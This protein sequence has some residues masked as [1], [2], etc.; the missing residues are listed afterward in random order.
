MSNNQKM[1]EV[2]RCRWRQLMETKVGIDKIGVYIPP[3]YLDMDNLADAR[4]VEADKFKIGIGQDKMSVATIEQDIVAM[5][6]NAAAD[7]LTDEDKTLI[8]QVIFATESGFDFSKA[9][10]VFIHELLEIQPFAKSFEIKQACYGAT[11]AVQTASDYIR[12]RPDRKILIIS[13]DISRYG[14]N[15]SGESTQGAGAIAI[16]MSAN[17]KILSLDMDSISLTENQFDFWRPSYSEVA[18]IEGKFSTQLYQEFFGR[19]M[20][21]MEAQYPE[22]LQQVDAMVFHLPFTKMGKKALD[23]YNEVSE[24]HL[25]L[26][27]KQQLINRWRGHYDSSTVLNREVGNI[28]TGS[29]F[30]SMLSLLVFDDD[31]SSGDKIGLFSYGSGAVAELITGTIEDQYLTTINKESILAHFNRREELDIER[32]EEIYQARIPMSDDKVIVCE[33]PIEEGFYLAEVDAHRRY[34]GNTKRK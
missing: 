22:R 33:N 28:Y 1:V 7:I 32:Y 30:L 23:Y 9:A 11:A 5:G 16:L 29:L 17:P 12:L 13:S 18:L 27:K 15:T 4:G 8:D 34:Y 10:S 6:A 26:D 24:T 31:L 19:I 3:Y 21:R 25:D 2:E 20:L 14:L